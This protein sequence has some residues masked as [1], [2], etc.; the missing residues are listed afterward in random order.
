MTQQKMEVVLPKEK[1]ELLI[2]I[3]N[4]QQSK[5]VVLENIQTKKKAINSLRKNSKVTVKTERNE[6]SELLVSIRK[7][8]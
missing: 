4:G 7:G 6:L 1:R 5:E 3:R 2:Q 8:Q